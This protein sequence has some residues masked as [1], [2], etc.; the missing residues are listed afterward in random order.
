MVAGACNH[1]NLL[2]TLDVCFFFVV[3]KDGREAIKQVIHTNFVF[4][5]ILPLVIGGDQFVRTR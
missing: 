3:S 1:L 5:V 2:R 4:L